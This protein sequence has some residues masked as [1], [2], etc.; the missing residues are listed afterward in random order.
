MRRFQSPFTL[1]ADSARWL[2]MRIQSSSFWND[3]LPV[4]VKT[5]STYA[6][7][8]RLNRPIGIWLLLW[9]TLWALWLAGAGRPNERWFLIFFLGVVVTRSAGCVINDY[10]D[11][12]LDPSVSR[13]KDRPLASK[14][15]EPHEA[16]LVFAGLSLFALGLLLSL[17]RDA[18]MLALGA[19]VMLVT[20]PL[21]KRFFP[22]PQIY[23]GAAF[24]WSIPMAYSAEAGAVPRLG[25]L[26]FVAGVLWTTAYDTMYAMA[27]REDDR[28]IGIKS[29]AILFGDADRFMI[30]LIQLMTLLALMFVGLDLSL[31]PWYWSGL[32]IASC[33]CVYQ[34]WLIRNREPDRC[35][36]AF[37]NNNY[38]GMAVFLGI[39]L[40]FL[41]RH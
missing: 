6:E 22:A 35:L 33:L 14:R 25:W 24:S 10:L 9:P 32:G 17:P 7:L 2:V 5:T 11:R 38:F 30:G 39:A 23:L 41:F 15:V 20:Y 28:K 27:D 40:E 26:L 4:A 12:N 16:L 1:I 34:Q 37:K 3:Y 31:G 8:M 36:Q 13:T 21:F 18:Q 19:A 29:T